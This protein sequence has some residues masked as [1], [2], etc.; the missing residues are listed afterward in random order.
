MKL[1]LYYTTV[2]I[3]FSVIAVLQFARALQG[4][5]AMVAGYTI[6]IWVS[7]AACFIAAYLAARG[8]Q[9]ASRS[10]SQE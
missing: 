3:V 8:F 9:L 2:A 5:E 6:P 7:W 10:S 1:K 4:W